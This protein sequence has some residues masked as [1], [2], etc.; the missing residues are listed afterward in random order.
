MTD[1]STISSE[2][3]DKKLGKFYAEV[4]PKN[5]QKRCN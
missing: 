3:R 5:S 4:T 2:D 1:F